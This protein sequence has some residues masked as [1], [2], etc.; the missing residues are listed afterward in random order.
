MTRL[1]I[2][3]NA[4][5]RFDQASDDVDLAAAQQTHGASFF[6]TDSSSGER[7]RRSLM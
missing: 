5:R 1:S 2:A 4:P 7:Q 6:K 3:S